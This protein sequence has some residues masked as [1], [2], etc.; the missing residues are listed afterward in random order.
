MPWIW[1]SYGHIQVDTT[2]AAFH[3]LAEAIENRMPTS[4]P[5]IAGSAALL[6]DEVLDSAHV[7]D[8]CFIRSF[9]TQ[10]RRPRFKRIVPGLTVAEND[11]EAFSRTQKFTPLREAVEEELGPLSGTVVPPLLIFPAV[12]DP[13]GR[14]RIAIPGKKLNKDISGSW[15]RYLQHLEEES[16]PAGLYSEGVE[17]RDMDSAEEG[18]GLVLA[19]ARIPPGGSKHARKSD[20]SLMDVDGVFDLFQHGHKDFGGEWWRPQRLERL[21]DQWRKLVETGV[22]TVGPD[23]VEGTVDTFDD[24]NT[25]M[26]WHHYWISPDW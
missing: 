16:I 9:L 25:A 11:A 4:T 17:R 21:F 20:G 2:V 15:P 22:W 5:H 10:A 23:G 3:R 8:E 7:P 18:F 24:A 1:H 13:N 14:S 12:R 19:S 6:S 26:G